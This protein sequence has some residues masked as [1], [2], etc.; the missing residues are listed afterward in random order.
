MKKSKNPRQP[1]VRFGFVVY[2]AVML[3]LLFFRSW[4][5]DDGLSYTEMLKSNINLTPL[6]T[7]KNYLYVVVNR[8]NNE[9]FTHCVINLVGN[10]VLFIPIGYLLPKI[11]QK[12]RNFFYFL[13]T[14]F[15]SVFLV[16]IT[17][18]F[19]L[20]G[21]FDVDDVILN[22]GGMTLGFIIYHLSKKK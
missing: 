2:C 10:V 21:S 18:L 20:L 15:I 19:T 16:E 8:S 1:L 6:L 7:I 5:W 9:V 13:F 11:W 4:G 22:L 3:W 14:C 12:Q 17:Q